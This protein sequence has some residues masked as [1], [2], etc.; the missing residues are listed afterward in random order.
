LRKAKVITALALTTVMLVVMTGLA[1]AT[2]TTS[3]DHVYVNI[4]TNAVS[5][6]TITFTG[7]KIGDLCMFNIIDDSTTH[8][9]TEL[10]GSFDGTNWYS[11]N[12]LGNEAPPNSV[13]YNSAGNNYTSVWHFQIADHGDG[14][15][16]TQMG[17]NYTLQFIIFNGSVSWTTGV[18]ATTTGVTATDVPE[19]A[20]I[21]IPVAAILGLVLFYN[22]RKRKEE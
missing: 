11:P 8:P 14:D 15:D 6:I 13:T 4:A 16:T 10:Q 1:A 9:S 18:G 22:H 20:T 5:D 19:F 12:N 2:L 17:K 7:P 3:P 21:A